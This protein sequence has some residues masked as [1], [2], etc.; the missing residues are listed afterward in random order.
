MCCF[1]FLT[2]ASDM[3]PGG[4]KACTT[5]Q[6][7]YCCCRA[8]MPPGGVGNGGQMP[9]YVLPLIAGGRLYNS[10]LSLPP[11]RSPRKKLLNHFNGLPGGSS[12]A[13]HNVIIGHGG[14]PCA[15]RIDNVTLCKSQAG[16]ENLS[17]KK[18][19]EPTKAEN[20]YCFFG[21]TLLRCRARACY[22]NG[23][24]YAV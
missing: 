24:M 4:I 18:A 6:D 3:L 22:R 9:G 15:K 19:E 13:L 14:N 11:C 7:S 20:L 10:C 8:F 12:A 16:E 5:V 17:L 23:Q 21:N 1:F 2:T